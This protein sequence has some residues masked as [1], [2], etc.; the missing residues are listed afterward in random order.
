MHIADDAPLDNTLG[1]PCRAAR[2]VA[3]T[4]RDDIRQA[5]AMARHDE[6]PL[7]VVGG[8]SNVILPARLPGVTLQLACDDWWW[9]AVDEQTVQVHAEAG[10]SWH[11]LV[12]ACVEK[13]WWGIENL[14]LIPGQVGAAPIQNIGADGVELA[15]VL[16][17]VHVMYREDGREEVLPREACDFAYRDSIFKRSLAGRV[18][19]TKIVLRLSRRPAPR[20]G[21]G[22]LAQRVSTSPTPHEIYTVG[23]AIRREKLPDPAVLGNA[24]SFFT[25]PV[26]EASH[27]ERLLQEFPDMPHFPQPG[28]RIKLAAGWLIDRCGFK[29]QRCGAFGMHERQALVLV[30]FGGGDRPTLLAWAERIRDAVQQRFNVVLEREPRLLG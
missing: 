18:V 14:A 20:L 5:L 28:G 9:H 24:G 25:N 1:L 19:V 26:V 4:T 29:G 23:C 27:A 21:Y 6:A 16:E 2:L 10:L 22:D 3:A 30:H 17:A 8:A 11:E 13:G 7:Q 12:T 15:D